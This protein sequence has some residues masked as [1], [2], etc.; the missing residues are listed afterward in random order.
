MSDAREFDFESDED[1]FSSRENRRRE[2]DSE[3]GDETE[4][5]YHKW[6]EGLVED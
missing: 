5:W 6:L 2:I 3:Y 1:S 4:N